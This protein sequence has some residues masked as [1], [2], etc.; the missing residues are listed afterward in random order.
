MPTRSLPPLQGLQC[1]ILHAFENAIGGLRLSS[2][3]PCEE[4]VAGVILKRLLSASSYF[5][6]N[7]V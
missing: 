6:R 5:T 2:P 3:S 4:S 1:R 7:K